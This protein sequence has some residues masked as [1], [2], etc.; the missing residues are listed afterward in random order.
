MAEVAPNARA[1]A[2][3]RVVNLA[4]VKLV[5]SSPALRSALRRRG[6][7]PEQLSCCGHS[8]FSA[9]C[10]LADQYVGAGGQAGWSTMN[11]FSRI[12]DLRRRDV[13]K[14]GLAAGAPP[15]G[16]SGPAHG[17]R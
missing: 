8:G 11:I 4:I 6:R 7:R 16:T 9:L 10:L 17:Q 5:P 13:L 2:S 14:L 3:Y 12:L 15:R 1:S